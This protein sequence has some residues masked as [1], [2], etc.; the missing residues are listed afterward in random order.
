[1]EYLDH[2]LPDLQCADLADLLFERM[3]EAALPRTAASL[4]ATISLSTRPPMSVSLR[5][6]PAC[7]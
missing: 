4:Q 7:W 3:A 1:M 2:P 6:R 5:M